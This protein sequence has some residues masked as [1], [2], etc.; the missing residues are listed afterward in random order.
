[1]EFISINKSFSENI[2]CGNGS[3]L[4]IIGKV[5]LEIQLGHVKIIHLFKI[6]LQLIVSFVFGNDITKKYGIVPNLKREC[7]HFDDNPELVYI[8]ETVLNDSEGKLLLVLREKTD[9]EEDS[10]E[11]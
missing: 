1:M 3:F 4:K 5:E 8:L 9:F 11:G 10:N 2:K 6:A 7:F